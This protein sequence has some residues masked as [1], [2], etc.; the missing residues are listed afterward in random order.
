MDETFFKNLVGFA[1]IFAFIINAISGGSSI[2]R[3]R[4]CQLTK[5]GTNIWFYQNFPKT[6]W[7]WKNLDL[8]VG[9]RPLCPPLDPLLAIGIYIYVYTLGIRE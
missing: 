1:F 5:G 8:G 7:N 3:R 9:A 2:S 6:A 4:G